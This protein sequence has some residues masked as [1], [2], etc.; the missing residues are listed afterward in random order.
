VRETRGKKRK[1][2]I[3]GGIEINCTHPN[4]VFRSTKRKDIVFLSY[5]TTEEKHVHIH[6]NI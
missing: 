4:R 1:T 2:G 5:I 3:Y 6:I